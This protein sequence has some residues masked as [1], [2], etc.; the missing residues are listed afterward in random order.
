MTI[1]YVSTN[2]TAV[3]FSPSVAGAG[4]NGPVTVSPT[5]STTYT[6]TATGANNQTATCT[7]AINVT[8]APA[9]PTAVITGPEVVE[10]FSRELVLSGSESTNPTGG[11][12]TYIWTPL[13][14]GAA[15]LDQ[16]QARTRVQLAGLAGEYPFR[17]TVRNAA[18]AESSAIVTV[19][20]RSST[21]P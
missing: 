10:T 2:A 18:G 11:A 5:A 14:T 21:I 20:F 7:V 8:P 15:V 9:P 4:L 1:S 16:G 17:L 19:R 6:I 3:S 13:G 12:L